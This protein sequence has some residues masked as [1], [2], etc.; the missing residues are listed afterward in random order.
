MTNRHGIRLVLLSSLCLPRLAW[1]QPVQAPSAI[2]SSTP[3]QRETARA[4]LHEG[5]RLFAQQDYAA[6]LERFTAAYQLVHAP[7]VG[8]EIA[9]SQEALGKWVEANATAAEVMS[10]PAAAD[11][12]AVFGVARG[13]AKELLTRLMPLVPALRLEVTPN[14]AAVHLEIDGENMPAPSRQLSFKL[15]PGSHELVVSAPGYAAVRRQITLL[16]QETQTLSIALVAEPHP[17][18]PAGAEP[19]SATVDSAAPQ[20]AAAPADARP[21]PATMPDPAATEPGATTSASPTRGYIALGAAGVAALVGGYTGTLA[22]TGKPD[23][24]NNHCRIDQRDEASASRRNGNIATISFGVAIVAGGY[25]L[26]ELLRAAPERAA[27]GT[28]AGARVLPVRSGA[29]LEISGALPLWF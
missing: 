6:A 26:W 21:A 29:L 24:P 14:D 10:L 5:R 19:A 3:T 9:R 2:A 28:S 1:S 23:C 8:I 16:Q 12:P 7:T 17:A 4:W 27:P 15:N 25:G 13:R 18:A 20:A 11:E 22:F